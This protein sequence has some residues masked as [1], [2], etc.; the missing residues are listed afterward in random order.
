MEIKKYILIPNSDWRTLKNE[1]TQQKKI[2]DLSM[3]QVIK[4]PIE[5]GNLNLKYFSFNEFLRQ[6]SA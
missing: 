1:F 3:P 2:K 6:S 4:K 5:V